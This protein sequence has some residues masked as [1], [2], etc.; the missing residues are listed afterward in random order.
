LK[1]TPKSLSQIEVTFSCFSGDY[2]QQ[3]KVNPWIFPVLAALAVGIWIGSE[4]K[5]SAA[6]EREIT[7]IAQRIREAKSTAE[8]ELKTREEL[9]YDHKKKRNKRTNHKID[10]KSL[11][12]KV[13]ETDD[14][15]QASVRTEQVLLGMTT[16]ELCAQLDEIAA[17]NLGN[18]VHNLLKNIIFSALQ[19]KDPEMALT[20]FVSEASE[21]ADNFHIQEALSSTLS[22]W[23][24][25]EPAAAIT[26][27]DAQIAAGQFESKKLDG[28]NQA[29]LRL[30][31][32]LVNALLKADPAAAT[33]RVN[34]LP[35]GH[36]LD[37]FSRGAF[38]NLPQESEVNYA[39][40]VRGTLPANQA[41][42]IL[43]SA[44]ADLASIKDGYKRV[45]AFIINSNTTEQEKKSMVVTV[46]TYLLRRYNDSE[47]DVKEL[48]E[49]RAWANTQSPDSVD[50]GTG[51]ALASAIS[52]GASF[53]DASRL[54]LQYHE[55]AGG[56]EVLASFLKS[57]RGI[58]GG[59]EGKAKR[60][61]D[62]IKDPNLREKIR[63]LPQF[64]NQP[65]R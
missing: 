2:S 12:V 31:G 33:A 40:L 14:N 27:L 1:R 48:D 62:E 11:A 41:S 43:A 56:D 32:A 19:T 18:R 38:Y 26:W 58:R 10:W 36:R 60:L 61:I 17:M 5:S 15:R 34:A 24:E 59:N 55:S 13:G 44:A 35:I 65:D 51:E 6:L 53:E 28:K 45:D 29:L 52:R 46:M 21:V 23:A 54:V 20:R 8:V 7:V 3:M 37:F 25:K 22:K 47:I 50:K 42:K 30:E 64:K 63:N 49:A 16:E 4:K 39:K 9:E 57:S